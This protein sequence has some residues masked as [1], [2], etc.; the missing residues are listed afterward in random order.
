MTAMQWLAIYASG[1]VVSG[2]YFGG[3]LV[4]AVRGKLDEGQ[5]NNIADERR[6][7]REQVARLVYA[8]I[9]FFGTLLVVGAA[10]LWP[11]MLPARVAMSIRNT[12]RADDDEADRCAICGERI[13]DADEDDHAA[14]VHDVHDAAER[15][16]YDRIRNRDE[17]RDGESSAPGAAE[18]EGDGDG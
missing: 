1:A 16:L 12:L 8:V 6:I 3:L 18:S 4:G 11:L 9:A 14:Y 13:E 2:V 7:E 15:S 10:A 17:P 5:I